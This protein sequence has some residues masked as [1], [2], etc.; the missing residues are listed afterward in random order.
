MCSDNSC[1]CLREYKRHI[2]IIV[3]KNSVW[4]YYM[5]KIE[6]LVSLKNNGIERP[7]R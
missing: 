2:N 6:F 5:L 3:F 7:N 4:I 1:L